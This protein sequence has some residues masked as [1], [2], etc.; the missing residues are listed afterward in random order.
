MQFHCASALKIGLKVVVSDV[1]GAAKE[2]KRIAASD[3]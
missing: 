1:F 3:F 2:I